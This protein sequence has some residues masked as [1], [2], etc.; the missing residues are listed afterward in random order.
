MVKA[1]ERN[2]NA[3]CIGMRKTICQNNFHTSLPQIMQ[4]YDF[5]FCKFSI[6]K[7][8]KNY[9]KF[10]SSLNIIEMRVNV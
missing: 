10:S 3:P 4:T 7:R 9:S 8:R 6:N 2:Q 5:P 1:R